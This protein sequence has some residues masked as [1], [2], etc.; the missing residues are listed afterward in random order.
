MK[1]DKIF[2]V[3]QNTIKYWS[4][5]WAIKFRTFAYRFFFKKMGKCVKIKDGVTFKY[6]SEI[7]IG[8]NSTIGEQCIIVGKGGLYIGDYSLIGARTSI[9]TT[10]HNHTNLDIP[11]YKQGLSFKPIK[12]EENVWFGVNVTVLSGTHI[13]KGIII[14]ANS[15]VKGDLREENNIYAGSPAKRIK[16]RV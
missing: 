10:N 14:G 1:N 11:I 5:E 7:E 6:P 12:I 3:I 2:M 9:I 16:S 13:A 15:V 8:D 4:F